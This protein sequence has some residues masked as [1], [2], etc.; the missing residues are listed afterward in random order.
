MLLAKDILGCFRLVR[1]AL[2]LVLVSFSVSCRKGDSA[3][4]SSSSNPAPSVAAVSPPSVA[5]SP[6]ASAP[7]ARG[8][9][10]ANVD[11]TLS[12]GKAGPVQVGMEIDEVYN[13]VGR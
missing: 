6:G 2:L 7:A 9:T 4:A 13:K 10:A 12:E 8:T 3:P 1:A 5:V 11:L